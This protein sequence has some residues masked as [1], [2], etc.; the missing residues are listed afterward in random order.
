MPP[1]INATATNFPIGV[2]GD[3][4]PYPTVVTVVTAHHNASPRVM[5]LG[6]RVCALDIENRQGCRI[7]DRHRATSGVD[8]DLPADGLADGALQ[9][10][11]HHG[12]AQQPQRTKEWQHDDRQLPEMSDE[13]PA[14]RIREIQSHGVVGD[15]YAVHGKE[16]DVDR[17]VG[18]ARRSNQHLHGIERKEG[19]CDAG[20]RPR[21]FAD[22]SGRL[23]LARSSTADPSGNDLR[24]SRITGR[25]SDMTAPLAGRRALVTGASRGIGAEIVRRLAADGAAVAFTYGA[26]TAEA[27]KL[28]AEVAADGGTAVAIQADSGDAEQVARSV[29]ETVAKLGGLDVV[30]NNAGVAYI[31]DVESLTMEQFDR[32]VAINV[33]A[34]FVAVQRALPHLGDERP[35]HQYRQHQR[36]PGA[37]S[38][39]V[40]LCDVEGGDCRIDPRAGPRPWTSRHHRQQRSARARRHR[41][42]PGGRRIRRFAA[43]QVMALGRYGQPRDIASVVSYLAGPESGVCDGRQ[44]ERRRRFHGLTV[45]G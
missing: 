15:E 29:D 6:L 31:G 34:I 24:S 43:R 30:V 7:N 41:H 10:I 20:E 1:I 42:E 44:L 28:V 22:P 13:P 38:R 18:A 36:R 25:M 26:S 11:H 17:P 8:D 19:N 16:R 2:T 14:A 45:T 40:D 39:A 9:R 35:H 33:K 21:R 32:L 12:Q 3:R 5:D 23:G 37:R 4:S 27:E